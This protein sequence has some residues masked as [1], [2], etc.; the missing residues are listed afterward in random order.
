MMDASFSIDQHDYEGD[1]WD[2][3]ILLHIADG[4]VIIRFKNIVDLERFHVKV[5]KC[6]SEI[7]GGE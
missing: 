2:R 7:K 1:A 3:C 6:I 5:G 4:G